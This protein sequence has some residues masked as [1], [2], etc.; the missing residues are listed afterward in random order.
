MS[1]TVLDLTDKAVLAYTTWFER[2]SRHGDTLVY[3]TGDLAYERS[4]PIPDEDDLSR[5]DEYVRLVVLDALAARI[6]VDALNNELALTQRR[7][8][9]NTF[10]YR[11][12]RLR[13]ERERLRQAAEQSDVDAV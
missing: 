4:L 11:A 7:V 8:A 5:K 13:P 3:F 2:D 6:K 10:E 12:T 1:Q 9:L